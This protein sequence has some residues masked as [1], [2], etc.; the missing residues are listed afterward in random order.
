M[1]ITQNYEIKTNKLQNLK[2]L[3]LNLNP[4]KFNKSLKTNYLKKEL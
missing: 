4:Q 1:N 3:K 2:K